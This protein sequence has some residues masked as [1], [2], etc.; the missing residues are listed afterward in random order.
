MIEP[1]ALA[2]LGFMLAAMAARTDWAELES[3]SRGI[4]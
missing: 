1:Y 3:G 4:G 2:G